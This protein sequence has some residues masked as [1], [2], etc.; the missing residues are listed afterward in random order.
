MLLQ[1]LA[2]AVLIAPLLP[3]VALV[4]A[5]GAATLPQEQPVEGSSS[6]EPVPDPTT[7]APASSS[8]GGEDTGA[9]PLPDPFELGRDNIRLL[10]FKVRFN[11]LQQLTGLPAE[12]PAFDVLRARRY[13]L[14][15]YDYASGINPDLTWSAAKI[16][17]WISAMLPVCRA[18]A[19]VARFP[20]FPDDL[21][22]L[23]TAAY[24]T[25]PSP[26]QLADFETLLGDANLDEPTRHAS[27]CAAALTA[28]E[29]VA[30]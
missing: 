23:L 14:G 30:R 6:G 22:E 11:K 25:A 20:L 3:M 21:D 29:F 7:G 12:D 18:P 16:S 9:E 5:C 17:L 2:L 26:E 8:S 27:V 10:P 13:E 19:L 4:A 28:L 1:P 24:G 15:D